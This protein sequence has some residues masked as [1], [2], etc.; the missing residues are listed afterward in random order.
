MDKVY[1]SKCAIQKTTHTQKH[2]R[3]ALLDFTCCTDPVH[4]VCNHL[5]GLLKEADALLEAIT[6]GSGGRRWREQPLHA[7]HVISHDLFS[8]HVPSDVTRPRPLKFLG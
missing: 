1:I 7:N 3:T 5:I 8:K 4:D 2:I 6:L